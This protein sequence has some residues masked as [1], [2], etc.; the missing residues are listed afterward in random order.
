M[1]IDMENLPK[2]IDALAALDKPSLKAIDVRR[3]ILNIP[4]VFKS[5]TAIERYI[6]E[7]S[8]KT[9]I[10]EMNE[11][12]L[13]TQMGRLFR[14]I[15]MDVG[16][17][18]PQNTEDWTYICTRLLNVLKKYF[19]QMT[20]AD[21]KLAF[22]LS[23]TGKL[24][25]Y[26]PKD[27]NGNPDKSHYQQFNADYFSKILNAYNGK[28]GE[29]IHKVY[30]LLP[31]Q[32]K[33]HT[34]EKN[35]FYQRLIV[36]RCK[37]VFLRYKY[38]GVFSLELS[39]GMFLFDFLSKARLTD[40]IIPTVDDRKSAYARYMQR[41]ANLLVN[42]YDAFRVRKKG[43]EAKELDFTAYE[44]ARDREI[45]NTFDRMIREELQIDNYINLKK[46]CW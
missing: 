33:G 16:F 25:D 44:I 23:V 42:R 32:Q 35:G 36:E 12:D 2:K 39:D 19:Y 30:K 34:E 37:I 27:K 14:F 24:D 43:E 5:L 3:Q 8:T 13:I 29:I 22:E 46:L 18:I 15:A 17:I 20:I 1:N 7:A 28:Q 38:I 9:P 26:L 45:K 21:I 6:F 40:D 10:G 31:E 4:D 41:A 11:N